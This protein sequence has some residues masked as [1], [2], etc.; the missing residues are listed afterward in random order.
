MPDTTERV[1]LRDIPL[2]GERIAVLDQQPV[3]AVGAAHQRERALQFLAA[4]EQAQLALFQRGADP[5]LVFRAV[6]ESAPM[7]LVRRIDAAIPHDDF[8]GAVLLRRD[9]AFE[10]GVVEGMVLGLH[11]QS[12]DA[13]DRATVP[14]ERP[15]I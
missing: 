15:M 10:G 8:A 3:L 7:R 11:R 1:L 4:Q 6:V 5:L 14:W 2:R 12:F 13:R 9:H